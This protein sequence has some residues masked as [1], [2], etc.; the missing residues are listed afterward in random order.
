MNKETYLDKEVGYT[1]TTEERT[2]TQKDLKT[3]YSLWGETEN[4]F[5]DDEFAKSVELNFKGKI[6]AG[7]FLISVMMGKLDTMATGG[8]FTF[9]AALVG[10]NDVKFISPAYPGDRLRLKGELLSKRA[11]SKGH[12]L[13]DWKWT[14]INQDNTIITTGVNTELFS[15]AMV[16]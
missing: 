4:L 9:N 11:T 6:V 7:M 16:S 8:G 10:M 5:T 3:F 13:V 14:L 2:I 12:T 15:K 1:F